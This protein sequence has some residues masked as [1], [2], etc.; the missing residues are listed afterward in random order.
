MAQN[1][2][3]FFLYHQGDN[4]RAYNLLGCQYDSRDESAVFR[5]WAPNAASISVVGDWNDWNPQADIMTQVTDSG[6]WEAAASG[7]KPLQHYMF[8]IL[9][10]DDT[11]GLK[12][13]PFAFFIEPGDDKAAIV[14]DLGSFEWRDQDW[15]K[16]RKKQSFRGKPLNMYELHPG[17]WKRRADGGYLSYSELADELVPYVSDMGYT[18]I[19]L[20]PVMEHAHAR[21]WG[22]QVFGYYAATSRFGEPRDLMAFIDRCHQAGIGVILDWVPS[23]FPKDA[24]G[25]AYFDGTSIYAPEESDISERREWG[26][27][28]F[29]FARPEVQSFLI[30]NAIFWLETYHADGLSADSISAMIFGSTG[31]RAY[32]GQPDRAFRAYSGVENSDA[33]AFLQKLNKTVSEECPGA[34]MIA[35]ES[36]SWLIVTKPTYEDGLGFHLRRDNAWRDDILDYIRIDPIYRAMAHEKITESLYSAFNERFILPISHNE[37]VNGKK[38]LISKMPGDIETKFAGVRAFLGYMMAHPGKKISFMGYEIGQFNEWDFASS[39][40]WR[41]LDNPE[42]RRLFDYVKALNAFYRQTPAL[43]EIDDNWDG[44]RWISSEDN[45]QNIIIFQRID[46]KGKALTVVQNFAPVKRENYRFGI[47]RDGYYVE[48]FN[49]DRLEYGG[50]GNQNGTL[51]AT[52]D[53]LHGFAHSLSMTIPPLSTVYIRRIGQ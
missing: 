37:V 32:S 42:H 3:P 8:S 48:V 22:Y 23:H 44:F 29:D 9:R 24:V 5:V 2:L 33:I 45:T 34:I 17:S 13:D 52:E 50:W 21:S 43:W 27:S 41:L 26:T 6:I 30:S 35:E 47:D 14:Y 51:R 4:I 18:H 31:A 1:D 7:V 11:R 36:S 20:T 38:A 53:P 39:L 16:Q 15:M 25:L 46:K 12:S 49:S 40:D 28:N 19:E 10:R